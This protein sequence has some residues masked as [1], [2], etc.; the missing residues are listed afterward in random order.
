R[1]AES[2]AQRWGGEVLEAESLDAN[3]HLLA[4]PECSLVIGDRS[5]PGITARPHDQH[6]LNTRITGVNYVPGARSEL[7]DRWRSTFMPDDSHWEALWRLVGSC[8]VGGNPHR[9]LLF[10]HGPT[11]T[12]KTQLAGLIKKVL[13]TYGGPGSSSIFR[14]HLDDRPRVDLLAVMRLRV[15]FMDEAGDAWELHGD[16]VKHLTGGEELTARGMIKDYYITRPLE[17]TALITT[18]AMPKIKDPDLALL[19]RLKIIPFRRSLSVREED[20]TMRER[21]L[22]DPATLEAV[23]AEM[24]AGLIRAQVHGVYNLPPE[25]DE[26]LS[27]AYG[28]ITDV[29]DVGSFIDEL[30]GRNLLIPE[31]T[32]SHCVKLSEL[33]EI[34]L[35]VCPHSMVAKAKDPRKELGKQLRLLQSPG[36][37]GLQTK[38][39]NGGTRLLGWRLNVDVYRAISEL[40]TR[41]MFKG[42]DN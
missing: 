13:G 10:F 29:E 23:F 40:A 2:H 37:T 3:F 7:L 5:E 17:C 11:T 31:E 9:H 35:A 39:I 32:A 33:H 30:R 15:A 41:S 18:N 34:F 36:V 27:D 42:V 28:E 22:H 12:G 19:R 21:M 8:L 20:E 16:R 38:N 4:T 1:K 6:D 14:G 24:V 26:A 25:F